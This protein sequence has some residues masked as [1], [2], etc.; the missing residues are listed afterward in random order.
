MPFYVTC[1][2][3]HLTISILK[4]VDILSTV[5]LAATCTRVNDLLAISSKD[6]LDRVAR[7]VHLQKVCLL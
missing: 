6:Q 1:L 3:P 4:K 7:L 2:P 5:Q